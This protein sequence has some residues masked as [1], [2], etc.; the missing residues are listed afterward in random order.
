ML[1]A[2]ATLSVVT[3]AVL[4]GGLVSGRIESLPFHSANGILLDLLTLLLVI[5]TVLVWRPGR[6]PGWLPI[7]VGLLFV[8]TQVQLDL[9]FVRSLALHV[10]LG[11]ALV[12]SHVLLLMYAW[13]HLLPE[14]SR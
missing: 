3:Q 7:G 10:P 9:G 1:T 4:A 8:L 12:T 13:R 11:V 14:R 2:L 6:G 5:S